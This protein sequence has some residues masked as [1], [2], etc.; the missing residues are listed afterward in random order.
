MTLKKCEGSIHDI[1]PRKHIVQFISAD[2]RFTDE[3]GKELDNKYYIRDRLLHNFPVG[4]GY[5]YRRCLQTGPILNVVLKY[6][7]WSKT[8]LHDLEYALLNLR[9]YC[10]EH[11]IDSLVFTQ[12]SFGEIR[13]IDAYDL[14]NDVFS[15]WHGTISILYDKKTTDDSA[16]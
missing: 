10:E 3:L 7:Y 6:F 14:V 15:S 12:H 8:T 2:Y 9:Y 16:A 13:W 4:N 5:Y 1:I 11:G